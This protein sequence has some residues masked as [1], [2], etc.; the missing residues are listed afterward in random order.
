VIIV[1]NEKKEQVSSEDVGR[2]WW[3]NMLGW[4]GIAW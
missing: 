1:E 3:K 2:P 4:I